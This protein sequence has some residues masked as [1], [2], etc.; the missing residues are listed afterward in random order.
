MSR[1][2][3]D[4]LS[5]R[6]WTYWRMGS[7]WTPWPAW[8]TRQAHK[9]AGLV[10]QVPQSPSHANQVRQ[11][12]CLCSA[13]TTDT[14]I[15]HALCYMVPADLSHSE[16]L[17]DIVG[18]YVTSWCCRCRLCCLHGYCL[19]T[20]YS[21]A[22]VLQQLK[23]ACVPPAACSLYKIMPTPACTKSCRVETQGSHMP[24]CLHACTTCM[25]AVSNTTCS[26]PVL[27][28]PC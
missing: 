12:M 10:H 14:M 11:G 1:G 15:W 9:D 5:C 3:T 7:Q 2:S 8:C 13:C 21:A 18:C 16:A 23:A 19:R 28:S 27:H 25:Y 20:R 17:C 22:A 6:G 26:K 24:T 4:P